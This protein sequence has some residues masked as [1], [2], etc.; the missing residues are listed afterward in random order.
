MR[1]TAREKGVC[2]QMG[3]QG[4]ANPGFRRGVEVIRSGAIG[5]VRE[6]HVW[7]NRP[8][9]YWKQAPDIV[10][11][12]KETPGIPNHVALVRVPR[13][14]AG[15]AVQPGLSPA[16]LARVVGLRHRLAGRHGLPHGQPRLHGAQARP[17]DA[18]LGPERRDQLRDLPGLGDDHLRVPG[19]RRPAAGEADLVRG[20]QGRQA[21]PALGRPL[22][23]G[24][25]ALRQRLAVRRLEGQAVLAQRLR[26]GAGALARGPVQGL[27]GPGA[28][29]APDRGRAW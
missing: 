24:V 7:T 2:T 11:R 4:T 26:L 15:P 27:Q 23:G 29:P 14:G 19:A 17:A 1:E 8:F 6:V 22:P 18:R 5:E 16:R 3:N 9:K 20:G 25:P 12:P 13:P 28:D 10:A 21:E